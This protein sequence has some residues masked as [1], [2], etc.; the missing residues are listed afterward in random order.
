MEPLKLLE[1]V[2]EDN[3]LLLWEKFINAKRKEGF[4]MLAEKKSEY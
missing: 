3:N 4:D 1:K 2:Q